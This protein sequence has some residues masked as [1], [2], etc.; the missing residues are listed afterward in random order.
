MAMSTK[1][2]TTSQSRNLQGRGGLVVR[3]RLWGRRGPGSKPD[4][5]EDPPCVGMF[6]VKSYVGGQTSSRWC[7]VKV[8]GGGA[9]SG[10]VLVI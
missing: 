3:S 9:S 6:H 7:G 10:V 1:P 8:W 2:E 5:P 4:S